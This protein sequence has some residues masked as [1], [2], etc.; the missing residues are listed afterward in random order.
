M[1]LNEGRTTP[2]HLG[3]RRSRSGKSDTVAGCEWVGTGVDSH[4]ERE[5]LDCIKRLWEG[6]QPMKSTKPA[7]KKPYTKPTLTKLKPLRDV[8]AQQPSVDA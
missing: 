5:A 2:F 1:S 4:R 8:T 6:G 7:P 3:R